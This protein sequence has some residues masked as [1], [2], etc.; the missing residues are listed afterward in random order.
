MMNYID[1]WLDGVRG[2]GMHGAMGGGTGLWYLVGVLL[3]FLLLVA[4]IRGSRR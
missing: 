4:I 3:L 2:G 1:G